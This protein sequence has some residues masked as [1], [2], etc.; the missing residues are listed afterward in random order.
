MPKSASKPRSSRRP[1]KKSGEAIL[2]TRDGATDGRTAR[3]QHPT[4]LRG[5]RHQPDLLPLTIRHSSM[6]PEIA[7]APCLIFDCDALGLISCVGESQLA[8][9][10]HRPKM[11][12]H[13]IQQLH[14]ELNQQVDQA[15]EFGWPIG[16]GCVLPIF[17]SISAVAFVQPACPCSKG[18]SCFRFWYRCS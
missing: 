14:I 15:H 3:Y 6:Y 18:L 9:F 7:A 13:E 4:G 8:R 1:Y 5:V 17:L 2:P 16:G 11:K 12:S 10:Q